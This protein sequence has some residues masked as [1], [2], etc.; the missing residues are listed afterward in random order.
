MSQPSWGPMKNS[1]LERPATLIS[2]ERSVPFQTYNAPTAIKLPLQAT[3][4]TK[5]SDNPRTRFRIIA[6]PP[7]AIDDNAGFRPLAA[8]RDPSFRQRSM[9]CLA[10][11]TPVHA[12]RQPPRPALIGPLAGAA[13]S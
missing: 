7:K 8:P 3:P 1:S 6:I 2:A 13:R 5:T 9:P 10:D 12:A 11:T 4:L